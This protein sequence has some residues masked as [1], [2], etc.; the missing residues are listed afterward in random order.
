MPDTIAQRLAKFSH[1]LRYDSIPSEVVD[2]T[3][4]LVLDTLGV[5]IGST[6]IDFGASVLAL[7]SAWGGAPQ[8]S[9][10]GATGKVPVHHAA[11]CNGVLGHGQDYDDT[12]TESV[13]HP[14]AA[15]VPV[16]L[17]A[18]EASGASGRE[19]LT[20][21][22]AGLEATIRIGMPALNRF[23][24]RGFHTTSIAAT[25]GAALI[26][27]RLART[28]LARTIDAVGVGGSF[29]SGLLE[30][31]PAASGAKRL[32]AGWAGLCGV[33][34]SQLAAAGFSGPNTVFEGKLGV[35]NSFLRGEALDLDVIFDR[36]GEHW[37][38]LDVRPKLYPCCH[39]LQA[40]LDCAA[41]LR[42]DPAFDPTRIERIAC[43]V[44]PGA[45][46]IVC[47]PWQKK[48]EP[49]TGYDMRF[50]LPFAVA[51]MLVEGKAGVAQFAPESFD[52]PAVRRLMTRVS[53]E[54]YPNYEVKDMPGWVELTFADGRRLVH[55]VAQVRGNARNPVPL[56]ELMVKYRANTACLEPAAAERLA[57]LI[58][59]LD[60]AANLDELASGLRAVAARG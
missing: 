3:K 25:F 4:R 37:E 32:H 8:A 55:E 44:A 9:L 53:Y 22:I 52:N 27:A 11:F 35:Y 58:L 47:E 26:A 30:C 56:E 48:L 21:L 38:T 31:I 23:H 42:K 1:D 34:A 51:Q 24:L 2:K 14:S 60:R 19:V 16:A 12:H 17:A 6:Q 33:V 29:T 50:S 10:I 18:G 36:L 7:T 43:R 45:V 41:A 13:V 15:L 20:A 39:Y 49:V 57:E 59:G 46:N 54:S 5:C 28:D 40:F